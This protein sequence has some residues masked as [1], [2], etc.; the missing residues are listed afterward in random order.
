MNK[1]TYFVS[2]RPVDRLTQ[3]I[4]PGSLSI[5]SYFQA[6]AFLTQDQAERRAVEFL[7]DL[8]GSYLAFSIDYVGKQTKACW[9]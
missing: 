4:Q 6:E 8:C 9:G 1:Q 3:K 2:Y 7:K 5:S